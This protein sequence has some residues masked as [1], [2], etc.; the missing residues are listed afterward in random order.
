MKS[1]KKHSTSTSGDGG[2]NARRRTRQFTAMMLR[3]S[4]GI[5][6]EPRQ[7]ATSAA[8]R[9]RYQDHASDVVQLAGEAELFE[10]EFVLRLAARRGERPGSARHADRIHTLQ[11]Q[12]L[13][14]LLYDQREA[15]VEA[16]YSHGIARYA[17]ITESN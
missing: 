10:Q 2:A 15:V 16:L 7:A 11:P 12:P 1:A 3:F 6:V 14:K 17:P 9:V 5:L 8:V 4:D 13:E